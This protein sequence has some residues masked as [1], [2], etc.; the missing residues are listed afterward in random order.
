MSTGMFAVYTWPDAL[1]AAADELAH[2]RRARRG[3]S[4]D[5]RPAAQSAGAARIVDGLALVR[6]ARRVLR[7]PSPAAVLRDGAAA[8][9]RE[10]PRVF[11]GLDRRRPARL[12]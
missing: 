10:R 5:P 9:V 7:N 11:A 1:P 2:R 3:V 6:H 8:R 12:A 4:D